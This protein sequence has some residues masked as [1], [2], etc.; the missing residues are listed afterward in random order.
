MGL[1]TPGPVLP[2][3]VTVL[4]PACLFLCTQ[5]LGE[6]EAVRFE[7]CSFAPESSHSHPC[8]FPVNFM[9]CLCVSAR[10]K[11]EVLLVTSGLHT[12]ERCHPLTSLLTQE[13][14]A[15]GGS[16]SYDFSYL[17]WGG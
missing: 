17:G 6:F 9:T 11:T 3:S 2:A 10:G 1:G 12:R 14:V 7:P 15:Q 5:L 8:C 13:G 4:M 16:A